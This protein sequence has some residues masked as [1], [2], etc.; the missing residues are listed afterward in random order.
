MLFA[1][2]NEWD[3]IALSLLAML[4]GLF[5]YF[6]V[7]RKTLVPLFNRVETAEQIDAGN[8]ARRFPT[9]QRAWVYRYL[10]KLK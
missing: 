3:I 8:L 1:C 2:L 9:A 4:L 7:L 10:E 5:G 6:P